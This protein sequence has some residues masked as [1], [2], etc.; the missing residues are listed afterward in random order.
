MQAYARAQLVPLEP[1]FSSAHVRVVVEP[2]TGARHR[3]ATARSDAPSP[4]AILASPILDGLDDH[5][6]AVLA[7]RLLLHL[8]QDADR[9]AD[10][11]HVA[12]TV[13]S[14]AVELGVSEKAIRCAIARH[15]LSAVKRGSRWIISAEAV[16]AWAT[17][18]EARRAIK[19]S[20][21][22]DRAAGRWPFA[23]FGPLWR[24]KPRRCTMSVEKVK[25][26]S[27]DVVWRVPWRQHGRNRARTFS[28]RR[29]AADFDAEVRRQ[30]P[31]W[32]PRSA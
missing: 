22:P 12:Y 30:R 17:A 8:T 21:V 20:V 25:R 18:S 32:E 27:G 19:A 9:H 10:R 7:R 31:S 26:T 23:A 4:S 11:G 1:D 29:A 14:L 24:R 13:T 6:L 2:A 16:S 28:T 3:E 5:G 15:E